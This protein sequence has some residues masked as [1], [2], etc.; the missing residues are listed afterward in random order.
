[1]PRKL[2]YGLETKM[3]R[4]PMEL[5]EIIDSICIK[6]GSFN[7]VERKKF[8]KSINSTRRSERRADG[9][10]SKAVELCCYCHAR[11]VAYKSWLCQLCIDEY[12]KEKQSGSIASR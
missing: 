7:E 12:N 1:M 3:K 11:P 4:V 6:Y 9:S 10:N 5:D 8:I 2:K